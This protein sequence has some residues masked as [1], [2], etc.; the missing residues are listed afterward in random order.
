MLVISIQLC[1]RHVTVTFDHMYLQAAEARS[2][3][4]AVMPTG[5]RKL[6]GDLTLLKGLT[7]AQ[8]W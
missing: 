3:K 4:Q 8:V 2:M 5:P 6:G 1:S 7:P